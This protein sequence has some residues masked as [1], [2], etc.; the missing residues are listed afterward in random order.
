M[1]R[2]VIESLHQALVNFGGVREKHADVSS[3]EYIE[4]VRGEGV[5][6]GGGGGGCGGGLGGVR[7]LL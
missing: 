6:G 5:G 2:S 7:V 4:A 3:I 1:Y